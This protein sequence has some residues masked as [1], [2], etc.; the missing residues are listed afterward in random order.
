MCL[1][2][3]KD[4][5]DSLCLVELLPKSRET[6]NKYSDSI[7]CWR[8]IMIKGMIGRM[9]LL[10]LRFIEVRNGICVES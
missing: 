10:L 8:K 1:L 7:S 2:R 4:M 3:A 9:G 6:V 5:E